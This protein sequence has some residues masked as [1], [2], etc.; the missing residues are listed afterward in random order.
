[1]AETQLH[2]TWTCHVDVAGRRCKAVG[3]GGLPCQCL[4]EFHYKRFRLS[5]SKHA[6]HYE[7]LQHTPRIRNV[8][9]VIAVDVL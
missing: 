6:S 1:M 5:R 9:V 8:V 4:S 2:D 7:L 3:A